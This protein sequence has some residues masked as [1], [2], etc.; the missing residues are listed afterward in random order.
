MTWANLGSI[1][2]TSNWQLLDQASV[3][4]E[5]FR[6]SQT[7]NVDPPAR[8]IIVQVYGTEPYQFYGSKRFY[9]SRDQKII[10]LKVPESFLA[11]GINTRYLALKY[12]SRRLFTFQWEISVEEFL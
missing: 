7:W 9:P 3:G 2:L 8:A 11:A 1:T 6:L 5:L 10:E 4:G 12:V